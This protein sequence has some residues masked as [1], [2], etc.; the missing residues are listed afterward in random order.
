MGWG[1]TEWSVGCSPNGQSLM[2][3]CVVGLGGF[4]SLVRG[5]GRRASPKG[6]G[7][8]PSGL[9]SSWWECAQVVLGDSPWRGSQQVLMQRSERVPHQRGQGP[10]GTSQR[11]HVQLSPECDIVAS[12][13]LP[14]ITSVE[15]CSWY[16]HML[17]WLW[18][19]SA[20]PVLDRNCDLQCTIR[21]IFCL[22]VF[23]L[24]K[25]II[26]ICKNLSG[27]VVSGVFMNFLLLYSWQCCLFFWTGEKHYKKKW[28]LK[29]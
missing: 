18:Y 6:V 20:V 8:S 1:G 3:N 27:G 4:M 5:R 10:G 23:C 13:N 28:D 26:I 15:G 7:K 11:P 21:K 9:S 22:F 24:K 12:A 19:R 2:Y 17:E 14:L 25:E 16:R 29:R